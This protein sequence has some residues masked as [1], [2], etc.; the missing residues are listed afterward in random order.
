MTT[1]SRKPRHFNHVLIDGKACLID[2]KGEKAFWKG[3]WVEIQPDKE[4]NLY[5][6]PQGEKTI[7]LDDVSQPENI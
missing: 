6:H 2:S 3:V 7:Y 1:K 4:G 5:I